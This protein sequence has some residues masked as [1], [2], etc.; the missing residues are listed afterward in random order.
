MT[1]S[2]HAKR[3]ITASVMLLLLAATLLLGSWWY[4]FS[5]SVVSCVAQLEFYNLFW[6]DH[7]QGRKFLGVALG[8]LLLFMAALNAP[9]WG[10]AVLLA[11]FWLLQLRFL[12]QFAREP[13]LAHYGDTMLLFSGVAYIPFVLQL[14]FFIQPLEVLFVLLTTFASDTGAYYAG[15]IWGKRKIWPA[16]SPK[17]TWAGSFGGLAAC[18][19]VTVPFAL[20]WN[21]APWLHAPLL[22]WLALG[23]LLNIADQFGDFFES[24]LKR[25]LDVKDSGSFLPGHGGMLDRIDGLLLALPVYALCRGFYL[26]LQS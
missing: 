2:A 11:L 24:A 26:L 16:I 6:P 7:K 3:W 4:F 9:L 22:L 14:F 8:V 25:H 12:F 1:L 20:F 13:H 17:K 21:T 19:L 5:A 15:S 18:L 10:G 23:V